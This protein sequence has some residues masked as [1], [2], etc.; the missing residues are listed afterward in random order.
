MRRLYILLAALLLASTLVAVTMSTAGAQSPA[1]RYAAIATDNGGS[2][3]WVGY[4]A[5]SRQATAKA[6]DQCVAYHS[7]EVTHGRCEGVGWVRNGWIA[8]AADK[9]L[10]DP[11]GW[12]WGWD[13]NESPARSTA[14]DYC[15]QYSSYPSSCGVRGSYQTSRVSG[16]ASGKAW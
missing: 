11:H 10:G 5:T 3:H 9:T 7:R 1:K 14:I 15:Q 2:N 13:S 6:W 12:G 16:Q 8:F 4:G